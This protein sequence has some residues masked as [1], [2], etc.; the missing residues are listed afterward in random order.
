VLFRVYI[1]FALAFRLLKHKIISL[2]L[3]LSIFFFVRHSHTSS[4]L[5]SSLLSF[6]IS[7]YFP[8]T[9]LHNEEKQS[10]KNN[11]FAF[12]HVVVFSGG[13]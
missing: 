10:Q 11:L 5:L 4:I 13:V 8:F 2:S 6:S 3:A 12:S 7:F 1:S 9:D